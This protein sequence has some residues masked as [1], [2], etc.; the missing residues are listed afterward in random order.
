MAKTLH[1]PQCYAMVYSGFHGNVKRGKAG[2]L[3]GP[4]LEQYWALT[5]K[6]HTSFPAR[7]DEPQALRNNGIHFGIP[8]Y[9]DGWINFLTFCMSLLGLL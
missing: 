3:Q 2:D 7:E 5:Q 9:T 1:R 8:K 4:R 6:Q